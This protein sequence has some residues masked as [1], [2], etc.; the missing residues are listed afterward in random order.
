MSGTTL[1]SDELLELYETRAMQIDNHFHKSN[2]K[3]PL[4][5]VIRTVN[6]ADSSFEDDAVNVSTD[7]LSQVGAYSDGNALITL[8]EWEVNVAKQRS[9]RKPWPGSL[10]DD[11]WKSLTADGKGFWRKM[12]LDDRK[13]LVASVYPRKL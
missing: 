9:N 11:V 3:K 7:D 4:P 10:P 12:P 1:S 8:E 2:K 13:R 5:S 6:V